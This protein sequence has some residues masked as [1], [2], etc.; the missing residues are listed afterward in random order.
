MKVFIVADFGASLNHTHHRDSILAF[1]KLLIENRQE[2]TVLLPMGSL[3]D[4]SEFETAKMRVKKVLFPSSH[5]APYSFCSLKSLLA[6]IFAKMSERAAKFSSQWA[7]RI[8][9]R[10][11]ILILKR[12]IQTHSKTFSQI[13]ILFPTTCPL[14]ITYIENL[15]S[16]NQRTRLYNKIKIYARLTNTSENRGAFSVLTGIESLS[17]HLTENSPKNLEFLR[18]GFETDKYLLCTQS[19]SA[20]FRSPFPPLSAVE[21]RED[22]TNNLT[23]SFLGYPKDIKGIN[24]IVEII[25]GVEKLANKSSL[26]WIV[27]IATKNDKLHSQLIH[28]SSVVFFIGKISNKDMETALKDS[29]VLVLPY[30]VQ[31]YLM[32][33]SA[34]AYRAADYQKPIITLSG[35]AFSEDILNYDLGWVVDDAAEIT[36]LISQLTIEEVVSRKSRII[37]YNKK[38]ILDNLE[39]LELD[40]K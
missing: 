24:K 27:H 38:R 22:V 18:L 26:R 17:S 19:H 20:K 13:C 31:K 34:M 36:R 6:V 37:N 10:L 9:A 8:L 4:L 40:T 3:I 21:P 39:F 32:N 14:A 35:S 33:A 5:V 16:R 11:A 2:I 28:F 15:I 30:D 23:F 12:E 29:S 1:C 7:L 25:Q